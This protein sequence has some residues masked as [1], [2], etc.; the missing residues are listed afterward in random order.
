MTTTVVFFHAHPDDEA[1]FTGGTIARLAAGG[2]RT[3]VVI[4]TGGE[5]GLASDA[6]D[7][8]AVRRSEAVAAC[9]A[10]GAA[11][12]DFLGYGDSGLSGEGEEAPAGSFAAAPIDEAAARLAAIIEDEAAASIVFYD[13]GG[14]YGHVDHLAAHRVGRRAA[15]LAGVATVYESTVDREYLHFVETHLVDEALGSLYEVSPH[16]AQPVGVPTALVST[17][18]D[19][20]SVLAAKRAA[21]AAHASQLP[22]GAPLFALDADTFAG[23][24]GFEW[25]V[26]SGP[27]GAIDALAF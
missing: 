5:L 1:I 3:V 4:A 7:L 25:Y 23:V 8:G 27:P 24:Y 22:A 17:T 14:I 13:E 12:V 26:R 11:R 21:M 10:L 20:R 6:G 16:A 15:T 2:V 19:V 18:V 9:Q